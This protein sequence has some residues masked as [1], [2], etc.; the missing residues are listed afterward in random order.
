ML[1]LLFRFRKF[2]SGHNYYILSR[3]IYIYF[4]SLLK[5]LRTMFMFMFVNWIRSLSPPHFLPVIVSD[6]KNF[7]SF[8]ET[9]HVLRLLLASCLSLIRILILLS[10]SESTR[11]FPSVGALLFNGF[12]YFCFPDSDEHFSPLLFSVSMSFIFSTPHHFLMQFFFLQAH[13]L[14]ARNFGFYRMSI[15]F[16]NTSTC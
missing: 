12:N 15:S 7:S 9:F 4:F 3:F 5:M 13:P 1:I 11:L 16:T 10:C 8:T 6:C 2:S 14:H